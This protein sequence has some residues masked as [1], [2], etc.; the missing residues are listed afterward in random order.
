MPFGRTALFA[1]IKQAAFG[2]AGVPDKSY[3]FD[4]MN[5]N[6]IP[7]RI[8]DDSAT[9]T[10]DRRDSVAGYKYVQG[11]ADFPGIPNYFGWFLFGVL[12]GTVTSTRQ[13]TTAAYSHVFNIGNSLPLFTIDAD[14]VTTKHRYSS[15]I[16]DSLKISCA[17]KGMLKFSIGLFGQKEETAP[18]SVANAGPVGSAFTFTQCAVTMA[19]AAGG[20]VPSTAY[21]YL[22]SFEINI[23]N[24]SDKDGFTLNQ[25]APGCVASIDAGGRN[26]S[27]AMEMEFKDAND[28]TAFQAGTFRDWSFAFTGPLIASTYYYSLILTLR[29]V[30]FRDFPINIPASGKF[31]VKV[32]WDAFQKTLGNTGPADQILSATLVCTDTSY[33]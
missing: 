17:V 5:F 6:L 32:N 29:N 22:K 31:T 13:A 33:S 7:N 19:A 12:G 18:V 14:K 28:Y 23:E 27:G 25:V 26:F 20:A 30:L 2:T 1:F 24:N 11:S 16:I 3:P 4:N 8:E 15:M 10:R 9:G 21:N